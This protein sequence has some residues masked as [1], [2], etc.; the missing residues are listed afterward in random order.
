MTEPAKHLE[1]ELAQDTEPDGTSTIANKR[2]LTPVFKLLL[3]TIALLAITSGIAGAGAW[4]AWQ[5]ADDTKAIAQ[6][7]KA[8]TSPE[9]ALARRKQLDQLVVDVGQTVDCNNAARL[10]SLATSLEGLLGLPKGAVVI[11]PCS[12][13][14]PKAPTVTTTTPKETP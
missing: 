5:T 11:T 7:V 2:R 14:G 9:A 13:V 12:A 10:K 1:H 4:K 3:A 6:V 8:Q